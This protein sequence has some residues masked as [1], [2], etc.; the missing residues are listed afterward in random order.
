MIGD[1]CIL[2]GPDNMPGLVPVCASEEGFAEYAA[3]LRSHDMDALRLL[4]GRGELFAAHDGDRIAITHV[5]V[6]NSRTEGRL[7]TGEH[8]GQR[9]YLNLRWVKASARAR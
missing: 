3:A 6:W 5:D 2:D 4:Q 8:A 7:V 9:A 1:T